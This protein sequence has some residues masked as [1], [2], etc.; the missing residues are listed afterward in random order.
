MWT[1]SFKRTS[2]RFV[3][4]ASTRFKCGLTG[5]PASRSHFCEVPEPD[6]IELI[7]GKKIHDFTSYINNINTRIDIVIDINVTI[8]INIENTWWY[9]RDTGLQIPFLRGPQ[10]WCNMY[11]PKRYQNILILSIT[12]IINVKSTTVI[13]TGTPAFIRSYSYKIPFP[14][15]LKDYCTNPP[16]KMWKQKMR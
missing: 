10:S 8:N 6:V 13:I 5:T 12:S 16:V 2:G 1:K 15:M 3:A 11:V 4:P 14:L 7:C 9:D